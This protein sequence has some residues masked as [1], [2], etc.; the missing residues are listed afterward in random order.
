MKIFFPCLILALIFHTSGWA[1]AKSEKRPAVT[2]RF[3]VE[4]SEHDSEKFATPVDFHYARK[5]GYMSIV[6]TITERDVIRMI[7][8]TAENG[9]MGA[10]LHLDPHGRLS[11]QAM[12]IEKRSKSVL[13]LLN[14]RY[15]LDMLIDKQISDGI[16]TIPF[17]LTPEEIALMDKQFNKADRKQRKKS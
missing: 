9:T 3:H 12:S 4:A 1:G 13:V 11:L 7:P 15:V 10:V 17:G 2:L 5:K 14:G 8:Y 16:I 6:P